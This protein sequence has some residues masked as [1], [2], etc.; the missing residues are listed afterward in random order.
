MFGAVQTQREAGSRGAER[1]GRGHGYVRPI[2]TVS[3]VNVGDEMPP[4]KK[5]RSYL[6]NELK[7]PE[8]QVVGSLAPPVGWKT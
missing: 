1:R 3:G 7:L 8:A 6:I 4:G 5:P 2:I